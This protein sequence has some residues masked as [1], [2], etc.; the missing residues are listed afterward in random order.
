VE[1]ARAISLSEYLAV[2]ALGVGVLS[3]LS[4]PLFGI[5]GGVVAITLAFV[6]LR[7]VIEGSDGQRARKWAKVGLWCG[8]AST[9]LQ[10]ATLAASSLLSAWLLS[11]SP[12]EKEVVESIARE[13]WTEGRKLASDSAKQGER[14]VLLDKIASAE[15]Q[16]L[17]KSGDHEGAAL[18]AAGI[19]NEYQ[20][21][22]AQ[23]KIAL[24][25]FEQSWKASDLD[26]AA[27]IAAGINSEYRREEAQDKIAQLRL[28][29]FWLAG[30]LEAAARVAVSIH[31][32]YRREEAQDKIAA[33]RATD[34][35]EKGNVALAAIEA[36]KIH[37]EYKRN[38]I[39]KRIKG[40]KQDR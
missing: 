27:R 38:S 26:S 12:L 21:E 10:I 28:D 7:V 16:Q 5:I 30:D 37:S 32:E 11:P 23:D 40:T 33:R 36:A 15:A 17:L 19:S 24:A 25:R 39:L 29:Q 22:T 1:G 13:A 31:S 6:A 9:S 14:N 3:L 2:A 18:V 35:L 8:A 20:R 4:F 34:A